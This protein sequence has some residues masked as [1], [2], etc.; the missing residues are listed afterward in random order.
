[1]S[2]KDNIS[3]L[4][5]TWTEKK[6]VLKYRY[7]T[8]RI[9]QKGE[10]IQHKQ[11][12]Q[13]KERAL[14]AAA[15]QADKPVPLI[16]FINDAVSWIKKIPSVCGRLPACSADCFNAIIR[17]KAEWFPPP[18][19][20]PEPFPENSNIRPT[21]G[22]LHLAPKAASSTHRQCRFRLLIY[23]NFQMGQQLSPPPPFLCV[24]WASGGRS[25]HIINS[26]AVIIGITGWPGRECF[27]TTQIVIKILI[28]IKITL[29]GGLRRD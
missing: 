6:S 15:R 18:A 23:G 26:I 9:A 13:P 21:A 7:L 28:Q 4:A 2:I 24:S 14:R 19:S 29:L 16:A 8:D 25:S 10:I 5:W 3:T 27:F 11:Q 20:P 12:H 17:F 22:V 1:M